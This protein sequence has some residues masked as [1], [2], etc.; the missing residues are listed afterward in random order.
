[1]KF[2]VRCTCAVTL[3]YCTFSVQRFAFNTMA[4]DAVESAEAQV[5]A[6][7]KHWSLSAASRALDHPKVLS[8]LSSVLMGVSFGPKFAAI[9]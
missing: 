6:S 5:I 2:S 3:V 7:A 8:V 1:M 4:Q 9:Q